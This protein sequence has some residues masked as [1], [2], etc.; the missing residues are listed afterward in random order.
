MV[1]CH[2]RVGHRNCPKQ[3]MMSK[4]TDMTIHCGALSDGTIS[5]SIQPFLREKFIFLNFSQKNLSLN[6]LGDLDTPFEHILHR[7]FHNL[8]KPLGSR[9]RPNNMNTT[10]EIWLFHFRITVYIMYMKIRKTA[11]VCFWSGNITRVV[12]LAGNQWRTMQCNVTVSIAAC[13]LC[14]HWRLKFTILQVFIL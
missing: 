6:S 5:F 2:Q 4:P 14:K 9:W 10:G 12:F 11:R 8:D 7:T 3:F 13:V 1:T